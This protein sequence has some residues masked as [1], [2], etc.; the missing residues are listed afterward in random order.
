MISFKKHRHVLVFP[1]T[2]REARTF[3]G[4]IDISPYSAAAK[5]LCHFKA[6]LSICSRFVPMLTLWARLL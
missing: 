6:W 1:L 2:M 5:V 4:L 3:A